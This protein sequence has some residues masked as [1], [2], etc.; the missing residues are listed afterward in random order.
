M[1]AACPAATSITGMPRCTP[2]PKTARDSSAKRN[3]GT[4]GNTATRRTARAVSSGK[5]DGV[6]PCVVSPRLIPSPFWESSMSSLSG[7]GS[8]R[9]LCFSLSIIFFPLSR[10]PL[11]LADKIINKRHACTIHKDG[12]IKSDIGGFFFNQWMTNALLIACIAV[13]FLERFF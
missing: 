12:F 9:V 8:E 3:G 5:R 13:E 10:Q 1:A 6:A 7:M 2:R 11:L 4:L